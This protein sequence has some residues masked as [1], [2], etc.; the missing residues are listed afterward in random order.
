M[1]KRLQK[2]ISEF[3]IVSRREAETLIA[4][5]RV[6]VNGETAVL[7]QKADPD[8]DIIKIDGNPLAYR[9]KRVYIMLNKP[10]GYV[11]TMKDEKGRRT[12]RELVADCQ[13]RVYPV[14]RLD[15]DSEGLLIMTNDG[16]LA[17][18]LMHPRYRV[19]KKYM[20]RVR[21]KNIE[22]AAEILRGRMQLDGILLQPAKVQVIESAGDTG[23]L[24]MEISEGKNRQI[25]RMCAM[26]Q[27]EVLRLKRISQ[28][29]LELGSLK[30][31]NWRELEG[32]EV[33]YL[34][35]IGDR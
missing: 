31:G 22:T 28:G 15:M 21:G 18:R 17:N 6:F 12:V 19:P 10:R 33:E 9:G 25:R 3:G 16:D 4:Q 24:S 30:P 26:A 35:S 27:L 5:G 1:Q 7:G 11:T 29:K 13:S 14:G 20:V 2:I 23:L 8:V 34:K 32:H